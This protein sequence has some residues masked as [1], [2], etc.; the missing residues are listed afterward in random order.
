MPLM[1]MLDAIKNG[2]TKHAVELLGADSSLAK[3]TTPEGVSYISLAMYHRRPEIAQ[4]LAAE[5]T[6]LDLPEACAVGDTARVRQLVAGDP[7]GVNRFSAD[8][9]APVALAAYFGHP[10]IVEVLLA[11]G[12]EVNA[13]AQNQMKVAAIH[14]AVSAR[15]ARC[16]DILLKNGADPNLPQQDGITPLHVAQMNKDEPVIRLLA[17]AGAR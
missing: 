11:A 12:A 9:F 10:D 5:R 17:A 7:D 8:G 13:Q 4:L 14:A 3:G 16:V 6:D 2:D 15:D 1:S